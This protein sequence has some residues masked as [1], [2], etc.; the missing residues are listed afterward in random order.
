MRGS[1][2]C[3]KKEDSGRERRGL[4][5]LFWNDEKAVRV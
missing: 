5:V 4:G 3:V 2:F 1:I